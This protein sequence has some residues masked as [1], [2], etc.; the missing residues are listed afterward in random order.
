MA[1][2]DAPIHGE[3]VLL[4]ILPLLPVTIQAYRQESPRG[5]VLD[6]IPLGMAPAKALW[7]FT[8]PWADM[9]RPATLIQK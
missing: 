2:A 8:V 1:Q 4:V 5:V 9:G 6:T 7:G 3:R